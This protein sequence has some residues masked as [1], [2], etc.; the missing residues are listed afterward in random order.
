[1]TT[2]SVPDFFSPSMNIGCELDFGR[3]GV[4]DAAYCQ[5]FTPP[6]S[7]TMST[8]GTYKTCTGDNC[9]GNPGMD[10]PTLAYGQASQV[11]PFLCLSSP[12]GVTC[13]V[14]GRG[15]EIARSGI[16]PVGG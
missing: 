2:S 16:T 10:T 14:S 6:Q 7:V 13:T 15:F 9:V 12:A 5:T 3:T 11:G 8:D 1:L 4:P